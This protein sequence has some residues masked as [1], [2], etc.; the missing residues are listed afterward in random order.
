MGV[1]RS[2]VA[3]G[4]PIILTDHAQDRLLERNLD[5]A[6]VLRG[7]RIGDIAGPITAGKNQEESAV[8]IVSV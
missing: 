1:I 7:Y 2:L 4:A 6:D 3:A 8:L 5:M